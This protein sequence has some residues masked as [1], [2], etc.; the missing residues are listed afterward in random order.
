MNES[1]LAFA[2]W[3]PVDAAAV[4]AVAVA[5]VDDDDDGYAIVV[6]AVVKTAC[7]LNLQDYCCSANAVTVAYVGID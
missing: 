4:A 7:H 1:S 5:A 3:R 6:F 2:C